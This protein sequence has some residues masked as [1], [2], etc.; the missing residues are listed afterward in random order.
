MTEALA[1][2]DFESWLAAE[3]VSQRRHEYVGGR[4]FQMSGGT[5]RHDLAAGLL[6]E[7]LAPGARLAG[8]RPFAGNRIVQTPLGS[9]YY[10]DV[11][12]ACG[13]APHRLYE[14]SPS[15]VVEVLS[16][17]TGGIDRREKALAYSSLPSLQALILVDPILRRVEMARVVER[18]VASWEVY[19]PGDAV[20]TPY[21]DIDVDAFYDQLDSVATT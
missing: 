10:P 7:L 14:T 20:P 12:V 6:Y 16:P 8:C 1:T 18:Q 15:L 19:G 5:E 9:A 2:A 11:M 4:I 17:S 3:E 13:Q 21:A